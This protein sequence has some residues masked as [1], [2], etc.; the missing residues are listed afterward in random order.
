MPDIPVR[1][2]QTNHGSVANTNLA[3]LLLRNMAVQDP[4]T[5]VRNLSPLPDEAQRLIDTIVV[6]DAMENLTFVSDILAAGL[7]YNLPNWL[8]VTQLYWES[9]NEAGT[10]VRSMDPAQRRENFIP[11][12]TGYRL[13]IPCTSIEFDIPVRMLMESQRAGTDLDLSNLEQSIRRVDEANEDA[14]VNGIPEITI[15][16]NT[17]PGLLNA[18]NATAYP[19]TG[20]EAL[21][22]Q[23][24]DEV[25]VTVG[26]MLSILETD[27]KRQGPKSL[28]LST[29]D[30]R[31]LSIRRFNASQ[32][33]RS[34]LNV[35]Q[36]IDV[37]RG[38]S[39]L[40]VRPL[41]AL[42]VNR[43]ALI[44]MS[45]DVVQAVFGQAPTHVSWAEGPWTVRHVI[46]SCIV[47]RFRTNSAGQSGVVLGYTS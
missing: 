16:G 3:G 9:E 6:R 8:G 4:I 24:G 1:M 41:D 40:V 46:L 47:P 14:F 12:R 44:E 36:D 10:P 7:T 17:I 22:S 11:D 26:N 42:S 5:Q 13:P 43:S 21:Q 31:D 39:K 20:G 33:E 15:G 45:S 23:T 28:Y 2:L 30:Y 32:S 25:L 19:Y 35:L 29:A 27:N 38:K 37:N 34:I 18:P